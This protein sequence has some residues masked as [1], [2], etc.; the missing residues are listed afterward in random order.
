MGPDAAIALQFFLQ[1]GTEEQA[2]AQTHTLH[3]TCLHNNNH[4][5]GAIQ[6]PTKKWGKSLK[7]SFHFLL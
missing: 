4:F 7:T 5:V 6:L 1:E 3:K 2:R